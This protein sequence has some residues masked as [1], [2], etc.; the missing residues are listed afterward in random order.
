MS[1]DEIFAQLNE[2]IDRGKLT[3]KSVMGREYGEINRKYAMGELF[4]TSV[5]SI[6]A[7]EEEVQRKFEEM[8]R[9]GRVL[10]KRDVMVNSGLVTLYAI[11]KEV[12]DGGLLRIDRLGQRAILYIV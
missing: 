4:A 6:D 12:R 1:R 2:W 10:T 3:S 7:T 9:A 11:N 5:E 8:R